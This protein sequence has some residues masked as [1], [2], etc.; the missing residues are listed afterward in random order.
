MKETLITIGVMVEGVLALES[1]Y[2]DHGLEILSDIF[3]IVQRELVCPGKPA[4]RY[5]NLEQNARF[6][7]ETATPTFC[8]A[9]CLYQE[10]TNLVF[11]RHSRN[12][13]LL[14]RLTP[15]TLY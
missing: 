7:G 1:F 8:F 10:W 14:G 12:A 11:T 2:K 5:Y 3:E 13:Q 4:L 6:S 9:R 15:K